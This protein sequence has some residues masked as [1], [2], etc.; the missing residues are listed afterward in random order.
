MA[1]N[2]PWQRSERNCAAQRVPCGPGA[3]PELPIA[4]TGRHSISVWWSRNVGTQRTPLCTSPAHSQPNGWGWPR[5]LPGHLVLDGSP[6]NSLPEQG[7]LACN[8]L[9]DILGR[10]Q[11]SLGC[12]DTD[13]GAGASP[14]RTLPD[15]GGNSW[16]THCVPSTPHPTDRQHRAG[17]GCL[18]TWSSSN[19][20]LGVI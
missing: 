10:A 18:H 16:S 7:R 13:S 11:R 15:S 9:Q 20:D 5:P 12:P 4:F 8:A 6:G 14:H 17:M 19:I 2:R 3:T 1:R